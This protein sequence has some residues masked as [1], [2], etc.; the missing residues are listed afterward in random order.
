MNGKD[1]D[2]TKKQCWDQCLMNSSFQ[3]NTKCEDMLI[4]DEHMKKMRMSFKYSTGIMI[5]CK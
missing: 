2:I 3:K 5:I 4:T 1:T